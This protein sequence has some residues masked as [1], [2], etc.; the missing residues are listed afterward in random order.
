MSNAGAHMGKFSCISNEETKTKANCQGS[1]FV[2]RESVVRL[3]V[4][5]KRWQRRRLRRVRFRCVLERRNFKTVGPSALAAPT[6]IIRAPTP[7]ALNNHA[8][9][10]PAFYCLDSFFNLFHSIRK[11]KTNVII[12]KSIQNKTI[13]K[14]RT[15]KPCFRKYLR[16]IF[17]RNFLIMSLQVTLTFM[18][19]LSYISKVFM[20]KIDLTN[21]NLFIPREK[22][23]AKQ[24]TPI[25]ITV[26]IF[27]FVFQLECLNS[28]GHLLF[29]KRKSKRKMN[30]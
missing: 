15:K 6:K 27:S 24:N 8:L 21:V 30:K 28:Q 2:K 10:N 22:H 5:A 11:S 25:S 17:A 29:I 3:V 4:G 12:T 23:R 20:G 13:T 26:F 19:T 16:I 14:K 9:I 1:L 18:E 7:T